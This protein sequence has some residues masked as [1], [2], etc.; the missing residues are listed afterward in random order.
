MTTKELLKLKTFLEKVGPVDNP[1]RDEVMAYVD[2]DLALREQQ[3]LN[4]LK[5]KQDLIDDSRWPFNG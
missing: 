4:G 3:R 5:I 1:F 2:K